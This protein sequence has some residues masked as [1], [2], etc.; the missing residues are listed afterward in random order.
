MK[1]IV[2]IFL[3]SS[4][5]EFHN[6][7][8]EI[9]NFIRNVSDRFEECYEVKIKPILCEN[10]DDAVAQ[11]R[12]QEEYNEI[13]RECAMCFFIFFSKVGEYTI[14]EFDVAKKSFD[15]TGTPKIYT[16]FKTIKNGEQAE[17]SILGFMERLDKKLGH[18]YGT[19]EHIDTVKLRI[20]LKIQL[21]EM[22]YVSIDIENGK[23]VVDGKSTLDLSNVAEFANNAN[24][25]DLKNKLDAVN[26][27]YLALLPLYKKDDTDKSIKDRYVEV[28]TKKR[29]LTEQ[30][31]QFQKDIFA[32]SLGMSKTEAGGEITAR[33][34]EAYRLFEKGE[35]DGCM[36]VLNSDDIDDEFLKAEKLHTEMLL[37]NAK[38]YINE[39]KTAVDILQTMTGYPERFSEIE[40]RY[41]KIVP[42]A[43]K[44]FIELYN[45]HGFAMFLYHRN[46]TKE[47]IAIA[48]DFVRIYEVYPDKCSVF[49][50]D[51]IYKLLGGL[52]QTLD[53]RQKAIFYKEKSVALCAFLFAKDPLKNGWDLVRSYLN[54][55]ANYIE[56]N[57]AE[58]AEKYSFEALDIASKMVDIENKADHQDISTIALIY[59]NLTSLYR[60]TDNIEN[61]KK[62]G[63][64][65]INIYEKLVEYYPDE[66]SD[67]L[68]DA[69]NNM[70]LV[71]FEL[72]EVVQTEEYLLKSVAISE[73]LVKTD[74][75][76]YASGLA[77]KYNNCGLVF[78]GHGKYDIAEKYYLKSIEIKKIMAEKE[79]ERYDGKLAAGYMGIADYYFYSDFEKAE[80]Y[81]LLAIEILEKLFKKNKDKYAGNLAMVYG[82]IGWLYSE[83][84]HYDKVENYYEIAIKMY[85]ELAK[86]NPEQYDGELARCYNN[87]GIYYRMQQQYKVAEN[88]YL[89]AVDT[90]K[91]LMLT[92]KEK[93]EC[94][95]AM[96]YHNMGNL[97]GDIKE[98][99]KAEKYYLSALDI[100][101]KYAKQCPEKYWH[102]LQRT[103]ECFV[104]F[105]EES[106]S[107]EK[108]EEC[109]LSKIKTYEMLVCVNLELFNY[110]LVY[111]Y[112][113]YGVFKD[114][115]EMLKKAYE[116][117][118]RTPE[119]E[120]CKQ[121]IVIFEKD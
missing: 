8:M 26:S 36:A 56:E 103:F 27:E 68:A 105:C 73:K 59:I 89:K 50:L 4:L 70:A 115:D 107:Q 85:E 33:Q 98:Y 39:H 75:E 102:V 69:Y 37:K 60:T 20:L 113:Q 44:Y 55:A 17:P 104:E 12:K 35:L 88:Y 6:E 9:E 84:G 7:R 111:S 40:E 72:N 38:K 32:V 99:E 71:L 95:L 21:H 90:Y 1:R 19:F 5:T 62:Y 64:E 43:K 46:R 119:N 49:D 30:I 83:Y 52:Y 14:E 101:T 45:L 67:D 94:M 63:L 29:I 3:A 116:A 65:A 108:I 61:A 10:L 117:A 74:F 11:V 100:R 77:G 106:D 82:N 57:D 112:V 80:K 28:A 91:K 118:K 120:R 87:A 16:Y 15:E 93:Y 66:Y 31:E 22:E 110:D 48:E 97:Y 76:K 58:K 42:V 47:A 24:L 121:L 41:K 109:Y 23:C 54:I 79:P 92:S 114:D 13:I 51:S 2:K 86:V 18:Y 96:C 34:R 25:R 78:S 81:N 53:N